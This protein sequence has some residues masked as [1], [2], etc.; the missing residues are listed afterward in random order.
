MPNNLLP[1]AWEKGSPILHWGV[2]E[3]SSSKQN[4]TLNL[5]PVLILWS[6]L[7]D[8]DDMHLCALLWALT[9][10]LDHFECTHSMCEK[11]I[12]PIPSIGKLKEMWNGKRNP[13][14]Q[15]CMPQ[16]LSKFYWNYCGLQ[17]NCLQKLSLN[18]SSLMKDWWHPA[19]QYICRFWGWTTKVLSFFHIFIRSQL[20]RT[21]PYW[22]E[23]L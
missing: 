15:M 13:A 6:A 3:N 7:I 20:F 9:I 14:K 1:T 18:L 12:Y 5:L 11:L 16:V 19:K 2:D 8:M 23:F 10:A 17:R 22:G 4:N 21:V